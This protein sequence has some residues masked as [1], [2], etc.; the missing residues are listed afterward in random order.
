MNNRQGMI[1]WGFLTILTLV[2]GLYLWGGGQTESEMIRGAILL[3]V[4]GF[5]L[6]RTIYFVK[7]K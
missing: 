7:Q 4:S 5:G 3:M 6:G 1:L 2:L